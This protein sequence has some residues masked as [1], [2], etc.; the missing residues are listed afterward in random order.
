[1]EATAG[2]TAVEF[3]MISA[4]FV[5]GLVRSGLTNCIPMNPITSRTTTIL[6]IFFIQVIWF[7]IYLYHIK[8]VQHH[9]KPCGHCD[10][11]FLGVNSDRSISCVA[12]GSWRG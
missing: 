1:M 3:S 10:S 5:G 7:C 4:T 11:A 8:I 6:R 9:A 12:S 2:G